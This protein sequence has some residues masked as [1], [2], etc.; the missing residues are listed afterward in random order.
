MFPL[1]NLSTSFLIY[2]RIPQL[3]RT[4]IITFLSYLPYQGLTWKIQP[5]KIHT[6]TPYYLGARSPSNN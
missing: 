5:L 4:V 3:R 1:S 2:S 6:M